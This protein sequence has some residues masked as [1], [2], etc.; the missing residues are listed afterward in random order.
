[1]K[2]KICMFYNDMT[3]KPATLEDAQ[4]LAS[5][6]LPA[7]Q[8]AYSGIVDAEYLAQQTVEG[9]TRNW[10]GWIE[11]PNNPISVFISY[12]AG[13]PAGFICIGPLR[14]PPPGTSKIR[15][16]YPSEIYAV[17]VHPDCWGKGHGR[18][19]MA[20]GAK[21]VKEQKQNALCLWVI[22]KNEKARGFYDHLGGQRLGK[23]IIEFGPSQVRELCYG[24]RDIS[25]LL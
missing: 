14:T 11:D 12:D 13:N 16:A 5:I 3:I 23:K 8:K 6:H 4:T 1:M 25:I 24:W 15:P 7:Q 22:E 2:L 21:S 9:Y 17:H 10:A 18:A 19:L 20:Q